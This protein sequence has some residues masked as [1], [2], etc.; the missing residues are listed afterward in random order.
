MPKGESAFFWLSSD[1]S[2]VKTQFHSDGNEG[3]SFLFELC[4]ATIGV[5]FFSAS[6]S[7]GALFY[8]YRKGE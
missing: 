1:M 4:L 8:F 6:A 7:V 5:A 3:F 2:S